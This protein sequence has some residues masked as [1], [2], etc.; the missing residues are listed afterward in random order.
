ML[1][2]ISFSEMQSSFWKV[3][4]GDW[5]FIWE[6]WWGG[7]GNTKASLALPIVELKAVSL[8]T[9]HL[10]WTCKYS[11]NCSSRWR[12]VR[13]KVH[14]AEM[15]WKEPTKVYILV[16]LFLSQA[17]CSAKLCMYVFPCSTLRCFGVWVW[18][19][20][21]ETIFYIN[22]WEMA[23]SKYLRETVG[24][25][26]NKLSQLISSLRSRQTNVSFSVSCLW[27]APVMPGGRFWS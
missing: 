22:A 8:L 3:S 24:M 12:F 7:G 4:T 16:C 5:R 2:Q 9:N 27:N 18:T 15:E 17:C 14:L 11:Y 25:L 6:G 23:F 1:E 20:K 10:Q 21:T 26:R 19:L 13:N